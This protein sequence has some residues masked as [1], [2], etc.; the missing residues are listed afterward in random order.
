MKKACILNRI[1]I[2]VLVFALA[3][4]MTSCGKIKV[5][6]AD[7]RVVFS[8]GDVELNDAQVRLIAL[9]AVSNFT[10]FYRSLL[11]EDFF[12]KEI[13]EGVTF[14]EYV[15][16]YF[17]MRECE[18]LLLLNKSA[19]ETQ[20]KLSDVQRENLEKSAKSTYETLNKAQLELTGAK[21][22]DVYQLLYFYLVA[23]RVIESNIDE[24]KIEV[25][26]EESRVMDISVIHMK[27]Y[28]EALKVESRLE[29]G[30]NF[31][32]VAKE[33]TVDK[34]LTYSVSRSDLVESMQTELFS[35]ST[36]DI[37]KVLEVDKEYYIVRIDNSYNKT[38]SNQYKNNMIATRSYSGWE[39]LLKSLKNTYSVKISYEYYNKIPMKNDGYVTDFDLF[40]YF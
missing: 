6:F 11:G 34:V 7:E 1:L 30:E 17:M 13:S 25:S 10:K 19:D 3:F 31:V 24:K 20:K 40:A 22:E 18:A 15:R 38:L 37:S 23:E 32:T 14:E 21:E 27:N 26:D 9:Q 35:M 36:G 4:S 5:S 12:E 29:N 8:A 33:S 39:N 2:G 28:T 16:E